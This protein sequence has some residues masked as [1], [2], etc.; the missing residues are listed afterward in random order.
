MQPTALLY[1]LLPIATALAPASHLRL[2][3]LLNHRSLPPAALAPSGIDG[4]PLAQQSAVVAGAMA[5][6]GVGYPL[7]LALEAVGDAVSPGTGGLKTRLGGA[8][9][10]LL[11]AFF[12]FTGYTHFALPAAYEAIYP[13][14]GTWGLYSYHDRTAHSCDSSALMA[15][16][17]MAAEGPRSIMVW[18]VGTCL[19]ARR[20]TS[21]GPARP[22][23]SVVW[24]SFSEGSATCLGTRSV[25]VAPGRY[26]SCRRLRSSY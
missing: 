5:A 13:P 8:L 12:C 20:S 2:P 16:P 1:A 14:P 22:R 23:S 4:L 18:P 10:S 26:A 24:V 6:L 9:A 3:V 17:P 7:R 15:R 11:G 21:P 19:A 25:G